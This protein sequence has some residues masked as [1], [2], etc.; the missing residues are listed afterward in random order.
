[1][2]APLSHL[3]SSI[4]A[5]RGSAWIELAVERPNLALAAVVINGIELSLIPRL[6]G[7]LDRSLSQ[8]PERPKPARNPTSDLREI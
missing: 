8:Q 1:M 2:R 7:I 4:G 6:L 5:G 3:T